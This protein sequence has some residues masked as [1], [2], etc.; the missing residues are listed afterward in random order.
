[1]Q[2]YRHIFR[3]SCVT[4]CLHMLQ[5]K[6]FAFNKKY[7]NYSFFIVY[8]LLIIHDTYTWWAKKVTPQTHDHNS[9]KLNHFKKFTGRFLGNFAVKCLLKIPPRLPYV[10]TLLCE[11]LTSAKQAINLQLFTR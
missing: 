4:N 3:A 1:M 8:D 7:N 11:T 2:Y 6:S 10:A 9:V 5:I